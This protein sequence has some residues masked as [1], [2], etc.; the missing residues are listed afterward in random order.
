METPEEAV[1]VLAVSEE[2]EIEDKAGTAEEEASGSTPGFG[3]F[4]RL[5]A[6]RVLQRGAGEDEEAEKEAAVDLPCC[7]VWFR[8]EEGL[9][10][11][12]KADK[13]LQTTAA[14]VPFLDFELSEPAVFKF[15]SVSGILELSLPVF[16]VRFRL[17]G[18]SLNKLNSDK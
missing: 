2:F 5:N 6:L 3:L 1:E 8:E 12:L 18:I 13:V 4:F 9:L 17:P 16:A 14:D 15:E 10:R 11:R 7:E